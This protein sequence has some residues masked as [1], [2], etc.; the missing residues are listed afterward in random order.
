MGAWKKSSAKLIAAFD[1]SLPVDPRVERRS[2]F[3]YPCAFTGGNMS[4]EPAP[5]APQ[6]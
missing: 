4:G 1:A 2:M 5:R 3:G 6:R